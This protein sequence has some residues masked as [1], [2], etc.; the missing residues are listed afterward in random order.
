[1][2]DYDV[3]APLDIKEAGAEKRRDVRVLD[4]TYASPMGGRVP[5]YLILPPGE[6][7]RPAVLFLHPGQG[8]RSTFVDEAVELARDHDIVSLTIDAPFLRSENQERRTQ[9]GPFNAEL[10]RRET[11]QT[12]VDLRRGLDL[13]AAR[14]EVDPT[15]LVYVGHSLGATL[16]GILAGIEKRPVAY[17]LMAGFPSMTRSYT[18]GENQIAAA[19]KKL[20]SS[21]RQEAYVQAMAPLDAVHYIGQAAPAK[22]FFQFASQDELLTPSDAEAYIQAASEPKEVRWYETGHSFDEVARWDRVG[23]IVRVLTA[24]QTPAAH[25]RPP[26]SP[27]RAHPPRRTGG[28]SPP[29]GCR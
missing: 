26:A 21:E 28:G 14:P 6:G 24:T 15:R 16:G 4:L 11:I 2:F 19:F 23:W 20:L 25:T 17:V 18:H 12:I 7:N 5:A 29:S 27:A 8:N 3:S 22:I 9:A 13:L 1:M 10:D